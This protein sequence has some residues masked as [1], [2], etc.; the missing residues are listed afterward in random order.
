MNLEITHGRYEL[1]DWI[2][3]EGNTREQFGWTQD[4]TN[5]IGKV[6][7]FVMSVDSNVLLKFKDL[8]KLSST[9]D[10][11]DVILSRNPLPLFKD[12]P[13]EE[14]VKNGYIWCSVV[15]LMPGTHAWYVPSLKKWGT[16][17]YQDGYGN[18]VHPTHVSDNINSYPDLQDKEYLGRVLYCTK[19]SPM[20]NMKELDMPS[21]SMRGDFYRFPNKKELDEL[22]KHT[23]KM[24]DFCSELCGKPP[25]YNPS[26]SGIQP[27]HDVNEDKSTWPEH[28]LQGSGHQYDPEGSG[29]QFPNSLHQGG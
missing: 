6:G 8:P 22:C 23:Q 9:I 26:G 21:F 20:S 16:C 17:T 19:A 15:W 7:T 28:S 13:H 14:L 4:H 29:T 11:I 12:I 2:A 3:P 27:P 18:E 5:L 10:P 24:A 1:R 25:K